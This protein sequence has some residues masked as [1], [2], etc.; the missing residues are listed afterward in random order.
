M[1]GFLQVNPEVEALLCYMETK[2][3]G[4]IPNRDSVILIYV[5]MAVVLGNMLDLNVRTI[6]VLLLFL[7]NISHLL[8]VFLLPSRLPQEP[9][10]KK[11]KEKNH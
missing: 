11:A 2:G 8:V 9:G 10:H 3:F 4:K 1:V 5:A 7:C 6:F